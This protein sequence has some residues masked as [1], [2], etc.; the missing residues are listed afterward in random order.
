MY[1]S[2]CNVELPIF[3]LLP[4]KPSIIIRDKGKVSKQYSAIHFPLKN[5]NDVFTLSFVAVQLQDTDT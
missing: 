3:A 2:D 4:Q 1:C 5:W